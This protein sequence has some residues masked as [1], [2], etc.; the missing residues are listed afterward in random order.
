MNWQLNKIQHPIY[1]LGPGKRIGIWVQGCS[2]QCK[3][4]INK[5]LWDADGGEKVHILTVFDFIIN[6]SKDYDGI[7]ISGGEAFDQYPQLMAFAMMVKRK[8]NLNILVYSGYYLSELEKKFPDK[9]FFKC[10]DFLIDGPFQHNQRE[11]NSIK[12]ST[13][14]SIY[15]FKDAKVFQVESIDNQENKLFSLQCYENTFYMAGI[16]EEGLLEDIE[17]DLKSHQIKTEIL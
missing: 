9:T 10:L 5:T 7:T 4:C 14:Q 3:N 17:D 15:I 13:N 6:L 11:N 2:I 8:T 1:N 16:P 12:A